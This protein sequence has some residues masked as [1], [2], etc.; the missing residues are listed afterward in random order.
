MAVR[1]RLDG[2][3]HPL[4]VALVIRTPDVDHFRE[5]ALELVEVI[6]HI[7]GEIGPAAI[8]FLERPVDIVA[9]LGRA[10]QILFPLFPIVRFLPF[11][12]LQ[13]SPIDQVAVFENLDHIG[14]PAFIVKR[15]LG[16]EQFV[17][18]PEGR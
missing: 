14:D 9:E 6:S 5:T 10:E 1:R 15:A 4:D 18:D 8:R 13:R 11:R 17:F 16:P 2:S 12:R 7:G 3:L